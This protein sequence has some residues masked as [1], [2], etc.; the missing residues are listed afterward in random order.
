M[1][2]LNK[3]KFL[4]RK[5]GKARLRIINEVSGVLGVLQAPLGPGILIFK[6]ISKNLKNS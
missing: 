6:K 3:D 4:G 5:W 2:I 1:K